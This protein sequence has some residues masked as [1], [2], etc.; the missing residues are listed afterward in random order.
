MPQLDLFSYSTLIGSFG[1]FFFFFLL[2][3]YCFFF[4]L[5]S[6]VFLSR[7]YFSVADLFQFIG[8][9]GYMQ[10]IVFFLLSREFN[11]YKFTA[12]VSQRM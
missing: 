5:A 9:A 12:F 1:L 10:G 4:C 2:L 8:G 7:A 6:H 11:L 3:G